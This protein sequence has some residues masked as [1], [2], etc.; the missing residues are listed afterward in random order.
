MKFVAAR[1]VV[2]I[3]C[4]P[5]HAKDQP[6]GPKAGG[7]LLKHDWMIHVLKDLAEYAHR[8]GMQALADQLEQTRQL[9]HMEMANLQD[10]AQDCP[11]GGDHR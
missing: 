2:F 3:F 4:S 1:C 11:G 5:C 8:N 7:L 10:G 9:A 6:V